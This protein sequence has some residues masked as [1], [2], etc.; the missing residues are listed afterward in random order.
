MGKAE[1]NQLRPSSEMRSVGPLP[2][3]YGKEHRSETRYM[4]SWRAT[5]SVDG[6]NFHYGRL[7]DI[8]LKGAAI[9]DDLNVKPG[10]CIM[11]K[12]HIPGLDRYCE[13]R[14]VIVRSIATYTVYD[15]EHQCFRMGVS[16]DVFEQVSDRAYLEGRLT[17]HHIEA[18]GCICRRSTD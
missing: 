5:I 10:A 6:Q 2:P 13:A 8:S 18:P 16:F 1:N 14:V 3:K 9:L 11:L 15:T 17:N 7:R 4:V 12:I